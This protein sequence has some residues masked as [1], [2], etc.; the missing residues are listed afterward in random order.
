MHR[1]PFS[2]TIEPVIILTG[3]D[4]TV[5]PAALGGFVVKA[6]TFPSAATGAGVAVGDRIAAVIGHSVVGYSAEVL[7]GLILGPPLSPIEL[8]IIRRIEEKR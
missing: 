3:I 5:E 2:G 7:R 6:L 4:A 1:Q 8:V